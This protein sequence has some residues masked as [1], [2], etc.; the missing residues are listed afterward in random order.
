LVSKDLGATEVIFIVIYYNQSIIYYN[1]LS[2]CFIKII[3]SQ[4]KLIFKQ[5]LLLSS[6]CRKLLSCHLDISH[7]VSDTHVKVSKRCILDLKFS[8]RFTLKVI[9]RFSGAKLGLTRLCECL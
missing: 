4:G 5:N 2:D 9:N 1:Q 3:S 8:K 6:N 7:D